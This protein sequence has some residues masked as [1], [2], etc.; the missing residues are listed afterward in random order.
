MLADAPLQ[1][2][3]VATGVEVAFRTLGA[4]PPLLLLHGYPQNHRMWH[5]V[6]P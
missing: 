5:A 2:R 3:R 6:V 1:K 4:G